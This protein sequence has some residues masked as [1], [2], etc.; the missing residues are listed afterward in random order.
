MPAAVMIVEAPSGESVF[1]NRQSQ[2]MSEQYLGRSVMSGVEDLCNLY[3]RG[4]FKLV[5]ADGRVYEFDEWPVM[6]SL[7]A[8]EVVRNEE[9]IQRMAD[10]TQL[11]LSCNS[12][13][14]YD[15]EGSVVAGVLVVSD[16][17]ER[18][19]AVEEHAYHA[20]LLDNIHDAV[21]ATDEQFVVTAWNK[22]AEQMFGWTANEA[23]GRK[24][25]EVI[26]TEYSDVEMAQTL[27]QLSEMGGFRGDMI[28]YHKDGTPVYTE[29][30]TIA[31]RG[32]QE[33][34]GEIT[35]YLNITRDIT[36]RKLA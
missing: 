26:P 17:T 20:H 32:E 27:R 29:A 33:E 4:V 7:R 34:E 14:I 3:D 30:R 36:E 19:Q 5:R 11:W 28:M 8:G 16:I 21:I 31:L 9:L 10:G 24:V 13:P 2:Q 6:R 25:Y 35:G 1:N 23:L 15:E 22:A 18:K 12:S